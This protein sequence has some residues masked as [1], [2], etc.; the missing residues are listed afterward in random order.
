MANYKE[1]Q[2]KT[3]EL[4]KPK[5]LVWGKGFTVAFGIRKFKQTTNDSHRI[6]QYKETAWKYL[7]EQVDDIR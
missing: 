3:R 7:G 5:H 2:S 4:L 6:K 1:E